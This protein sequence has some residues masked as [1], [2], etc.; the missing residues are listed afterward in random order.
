MTR[1][2]RQLCRLTALLLFLA[3]TIGSAAAIDLDRPTADQPQ[4]KEKAKEEPKKPEKKDE[5][6]KKK[7]GLPLEPDRTIE[8]TTDQGTW[9]SLD[10]S[11]DGK[12]I[13]FELLGDLYTLPIV[14]GEAKAIMTGL[15]FDSQPSYSPDGK[16][17]AFVSDRGRR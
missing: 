13:V 14:G 6:T 17:I 9:I 15:A 16:T 1:V 2:S 12:T 5:P 7:A 11:P 8:F 4:A 10:V 3:L